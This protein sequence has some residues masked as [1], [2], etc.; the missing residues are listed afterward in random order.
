LKGDAL[1]CWAEAISGQESIQAAAKKVA[2][3][4]VRKI[5]SIEETS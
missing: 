1:I 5:S 4:I 3:A 2:A